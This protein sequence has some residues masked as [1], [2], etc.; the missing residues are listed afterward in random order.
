[1]P[2][3]PI[4]SAVLAVRDGGRHLEETVESVLRQTLAD[5]ELIVVDDGSTDPLVSALLTRLS[6]QDGRIRVLEQPGEGLTGALIA[7]CAAARAALIARID[8]GDRMAPERLARQVDAMRR[9]DDCELVTSQTAFYGPRWEPLWQTAPAA[10]TEPIDPLAND[11]TRGIS[12]PISHHGSVLF[13]SR[14]YAE[15]GG[16][17]R[18]FR[19]GQDWDLWY[20]LAER[21]R[22]QVVPE[23]LYHARIFPH[24]ISMSRV[25]AQR[26]FGELARNASL[27][28]RRGGSD[29]AFIA[30]AAALSR[31]VAA[32]RPR[33]ARD[34]AAGYYFIGEALRRN[35]DRA[36]RS[37]LA[38]AVCCRP[39]S[40]RSWI[41]LLQAAVGQPIH[42][43]RAPTA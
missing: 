10:V 37:Y 26:R 35:G 42:S 13:R 41:R 21:G 31:Q 23:V 16:Y 7:G 32:S 12:V 39:W 20:R 2:S 28:R 38:R 5:L 24:S 18:E 19:L 25:S 43:N 30:E 14:T 36:S 17:R 33:S 3:T 27:A 40:P 22:F 6:R 29:A 9:S 34:G 15:V 4:V 1:M 11:R 8:N